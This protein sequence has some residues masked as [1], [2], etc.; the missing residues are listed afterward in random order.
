MLPVVPGGLA[1]VDES[2]V[3]ILVAYGTQRVPAL[4]VVLF[5]RTL[6]FLLAVIVGWISGGIIEKMDPAGATEG[7][8]RCHRYQPNRSRDLT[9]PSG[10]STQ[11]GKLRCRYAR[12]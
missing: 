4:A 7:V 6:T 9:T 2:L 5:H 3:V 11:R 8:I 1:V 12:S 10:L